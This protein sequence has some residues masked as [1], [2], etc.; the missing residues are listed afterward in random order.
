MPDPTSSSS[1]PTCPDWCTQDGDHSG[2][3]W[4]DGEYV[5]AS[6][7]TPDRVGP[8]GARLPSVAA[9][10]AQFRRGPLDV[11]VHIASVDD[12]EVRFALDDAIDFAARMLEAVAVGVAG[13]STGLCADAL[14]MLERSTA[15]ILDAHGQPSATGQR[16]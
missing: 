3:H 1:S 7:S 10:L 2:D 11:V 12:A 5:P 14:R 4:R 13:E 16:G 9:H 6:R 8:E 15:Q